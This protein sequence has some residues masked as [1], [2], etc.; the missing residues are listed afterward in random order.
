MPEDALGWVVGHM[1]ASG[2]DERV[3]AAEVVDG[4]T[5]EVVWELPEDS[6]SGGR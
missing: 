4:N 3:W 5:G 1:Q 2:K 6:D